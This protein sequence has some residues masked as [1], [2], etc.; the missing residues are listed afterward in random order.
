LEVHG[1]LNYTKDKGQKIKVRG[2]KSGNRIQLS[3]RGIPGGWTYRQLDRHTTSTKKM[4]MESVAE[5]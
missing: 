4:K 3:G 2:S 5:V 1:R